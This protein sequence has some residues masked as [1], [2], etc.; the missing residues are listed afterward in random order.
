MEFDDC[1]GGEM[2]PV[3]VVAQLVKR[4]GALVAT[5]HVSL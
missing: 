1:P 5:D 2:K 3:L 4:F